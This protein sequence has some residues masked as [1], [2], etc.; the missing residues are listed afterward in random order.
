VLCVLYPPAGASTVLCQSDRLTFESRSPYIVAT[1]VVELYDSVL[2]PFLTTV[3]MQG[4]DKP[5]ILETTAH[6]ITYHTFCVNPEF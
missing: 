6:L 1:A 5:T 3:P 2:G 4:F